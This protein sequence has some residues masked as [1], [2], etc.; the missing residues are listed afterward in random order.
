MT[1]RE[2]SE[3]TNSM[4]Q[5][6]EATPR[7]APTKREERNLGSESIGD[8]RKNVYSQERGCSCRGLLL[9]ETLA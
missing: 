5:R 4:V 7:E 1:F 8:P 2:S 9:E 6:Q 3:G